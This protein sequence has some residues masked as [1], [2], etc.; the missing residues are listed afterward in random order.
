MARI[1]L[2]PPQTLSYRIAGWFIRRRFGEQLDP[3]GA[4][5]HHPEVSKAF[6]KMEQSV[7][8]WKRMD[9]KL[10]DLAEY[11]AVTKI[12][13]EWCLDFGYWVMH[14][15]GIPA[16]KIEAVPHWRDSDLFDPLERLVMEYAEAMT[17]TPP[18]VDDELVAKLLQHLD[19]EEL[20]ELTMMVAWENVRSR[21]NLALGLTRQGFK[22]RCEIPPGASTGR[23]R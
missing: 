4:A 9:T 19:E 3:F 6:G 21:F 13:C 22:D 17:V 23:P 2:D 11:A 1:S 20:V 14:T 8:R 7:D 18:A 12:G 15:H 10:R 16:E 5:A